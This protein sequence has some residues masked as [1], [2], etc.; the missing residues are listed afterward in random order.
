MNF[1]SVDLIEGTVERTIRFRSDGDSAI[2]D[3]IGRDDWRLRGEV[4]T[5]RGTF[6]R[7]LPIAT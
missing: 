1:G 4:R 2:N 7:R 3:R 5:L 6:W